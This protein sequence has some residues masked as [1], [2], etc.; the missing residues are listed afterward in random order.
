MTANDYS[1]ASTNA[2]QKAGGLY[3]LRTY[4][5]HPGKL[6]GLNARF[7]NH[8]TRFF[9]KHGIENIA[10]WTPFD[11]PES[12]NTLIYLLHHADRRQADA[13]WKTFSRDPEWR[14]VARESQIDGPFL[15][16]P[17]ERLYLKAMD[18]SPLK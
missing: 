8:T 1:E 10:Y 2:V 15:I 3:E 5:T 14:K 18:F 9:N 6:S 11:K 13:H 17:P 4:V 16:E 12:E 7:R